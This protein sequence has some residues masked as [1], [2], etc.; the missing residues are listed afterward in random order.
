VPEEE[1]EGGG[2]GG[3]GGKFRKTCRKA[4]Q[5]V[6]GSVQLMKCSMI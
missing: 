6:P 4:I 1:E 2:G 5:A 3:G